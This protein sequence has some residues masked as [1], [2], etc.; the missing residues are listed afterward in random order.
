MVECLLRVSCQ[1]L[2]IA[3]HKGRTPLE[4]ARAM[5]S[6]RL[7]NVLVNRGFLH[8]KSTRIWLEL[9]EL[10]KKINRFRAEPRRGEH[11]RFY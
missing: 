10:A 9:Q 6:Q 5:R 3:D 4:L 8:P 2:T 7:I 1:P 11:L